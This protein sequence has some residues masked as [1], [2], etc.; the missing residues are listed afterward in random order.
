MLTGADEI[1][2][3]RTTVQTGYLPIASETRHRYVN[4]LGSIAFVLYLNRP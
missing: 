4:R 2:V 3:I 1:R